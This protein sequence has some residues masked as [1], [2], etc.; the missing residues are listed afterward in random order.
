MTNNCDIISI[1]TIVTATEKNGGVD[2][3][4]VMDFGREREGEFIKNHVIWS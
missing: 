1:F 3:M 4:S 2:I